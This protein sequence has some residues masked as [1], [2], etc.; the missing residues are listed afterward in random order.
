MSN[1][2]AIGSCVSCKRVASVRNAAP[3]VWKLIEDK[4]A[5]NDPRR[6]GI[7]VSSGGF[8]FWAATWAHVRV[9][10]WGVLGLPREGYCIRPGADR[11]GQ[12]LR[13]ILFPCPGFN[14]FRVHWAPRVVS[15]MCPPPPQFTHDGGSDGNFTQ[16][17]VEWGWPHFTHFAG[18]PQ[19]ADE[20]P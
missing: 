17:W 12:G 4:I 15:R 18:L 8:A 5:L 20:C 11:W 1:I 3:I 9:V 13:R 2:C 10:A 19:K 14:Y 16:L 6:A 7:D